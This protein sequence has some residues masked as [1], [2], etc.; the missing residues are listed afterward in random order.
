LKPTAD[1]FPA[2]AKAIESDFLNVMAQLETISIET[3][4]N[5]AMLQR[6]IAQQGISQNQ[7]GIAQYQMLNRL[8]IFLFQI[9]CRPRGGTI[10]I[11][12]RTR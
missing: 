11:P 7:V 4:K 5:T 1:T 9:V 6:A 3:F 10:I 2:S 12:L 8:A